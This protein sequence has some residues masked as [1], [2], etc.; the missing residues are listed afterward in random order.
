MGFLAA[1]LT[2][3]EQG[4][5]GMHDEPGYVIAFFVASRFSFFIDRYHNLAY[6]MIV[7]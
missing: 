2:L 3:E 7:A 5:T 6:S 1:A 4:K